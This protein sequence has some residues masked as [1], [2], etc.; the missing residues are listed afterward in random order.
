MNTKRCTKFD[1]IFFL[2]NLCLQHIY[3]SL[4]KTPF[5]G[6][7]CYIKNGILNK[8]YRKINNNYKKKKSSVRELIQKITQ[9][10]GKQFLNKKR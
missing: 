2:A 8:L 3:G 1:F 5:R 9:I 4:F 6:A 7:F 10:F